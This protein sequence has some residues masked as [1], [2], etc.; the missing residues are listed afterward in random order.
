GEKLYKR[1]RRRPEDVERKFICVWDG[2]DKSYGTLHHLNTHMT[3]KK[4]GEKKTSAEY[5]KIKK[6]WENRKAQEEQRKVA[7]RAIS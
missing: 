7:N 6:Q 5:E 4:H 1:R 3:I 2:C